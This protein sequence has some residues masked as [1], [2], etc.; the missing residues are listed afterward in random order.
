MAPVTCVWTDH[1]SEQ[2]ALGGR[3]GWD[4]AGRAPLPPHGPPQ[5]R[6][7]WE[8]LCCPGRSPHQTRNPINT[9]IPLETPESILNALAFFCMKEA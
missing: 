7:G 8:G 1:S 5:G 4:P 2:G 3:G 9:L 6:A